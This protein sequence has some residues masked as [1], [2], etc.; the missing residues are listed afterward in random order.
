[1]GKYKVTS[2]DGQTY[3]INAPDGATDEEVMAYAQRSFKMAKAP[4]AP[5]KPFGQKLN[6]GIA[7]IARQIGLT[8]RYGVEGLGN[9]LNFLSSPIRTGMNAL[10]ANVAPANFS[11]IA[12]SIG[13]PEP[14][15]A[16]E[17]VVGD[18]SRML[19]GSAVPIGLANN[20]AKNTTGLTQ[21]IS[22][23]M[24]ANP[25]S[26]LVSAGSAGAAGG[27]TRESG[28]NEVAQFLASLAGG[29]G[30]PIA[31]NAGS[32]LM[33]TM[34][35]MRAPVQPQTIDI[36][37]ENAFKGSDIDFGKLP[38]DIQNS[39]RNDVQQALSTG[40]DV[41][42][43]ALRRLAD[44]RLVG[45]T[46]TRAGITLDPAVVTQQKNLS[47]LGVNSKDIAAQ[48]LA[49]VEN[50]N[51]AQFIEM[52]NKLGAA[53]G[54]DNEAA[55]SMLSGN[56]ADIAALNKSKISE[57]YNA[58]R[59]SAGRAAPLDPSH[60]TQKL[61]DTLN[62]A[63]LEAFLPAE[64]R[65]MVNGFAGGKIPLNVNTAEQFK[66]IIG[67]AQRA[68]QDGNVK[69]ALGLVR[70]SLDETP[71]LGAPR[72]AGS[73]L[74]LPGQNQASLGQESIDAFNKARAANREFMG[75]VEQTPALAATMD[76]A[77]VKGF[78][79]KY[80]LRGDSKQLKNTLNVLGDNPQ[81]IQSIRE[82]VL[83]H[84]K[85]KAV[86]GASD[87][88]G[89]FSQSRYN[90]ALKMLGNNK[91]N[92]LF[93]PEEIVQ[94]KALGRVSSYEQFQ[95]VGAAVN[96]SNTAGAMG[97]MLER[98]GNSPILSKIPMGKMLAEP[99]QNI[100]VGINSKNAMNVPNSISIPQFLTE[101][102]KQQMMLNPAIFGL[103]GYQNQ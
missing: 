78:F 92:L 54:L 51:N 36:K 61:G 47:K 44:Y 56:L 85:E 96:N 53:K 43:D 60:F 42:P 21:A 100:S 12:S 48:Q 99:I 76:D 91:L 16:T 65:G 101:Q 3:E 83:S 2:P 81:A 13:L 86:S 102:Q 69:M 98:I 84:L 88:V 103:L 9:T 55:G 37:I 52:M 24:S 82:N 72:Q 31:M 41:S 70:Q 50:Q 26:Q 89:K 23:Q 29:I 22:Q 79:D 28:G 62:Q 33:N 32:K 64:I 7:D 63:N 18:A 4:A 49:Q 39:I 68:S 58:A 15:N 30:A 25:L 90:A 17:R 59:D 27:A 20:L 19:A 73:Q 8:A 40:N 45:A 5:E 93:S 34:Q 71:L 74:A 10:G 87:E 97:G 46:P 95:P 35:S 38:K 77:S 94:L 66:T 75:K 11:N 80:V 67:N 1:M 6:E 57:L 14:Q